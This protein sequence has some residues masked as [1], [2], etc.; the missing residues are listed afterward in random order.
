MRRGVYGGS[1]DPVHVGHVQ[2]AELAAQ[3]ARLD[4]VD[5]VPAAK[6]PFKRRGPQASDHDRLAMLAL[7]LAD[8][9]RLEV[10]DLEITR[11]GVSYTVDTLRELHRRHPGDELYFLMGA[12]SLQDLPQ[13]REPDEIL[14]LA[15]PIVVARRGEPAPDWQVLAPL[16]DES[17]M[18][19]IRR[20][21]IAEMVAHV[22]S[23]EVRRRLAS[24][25]TVEGML[26]PAVAHYI[27]Q[28]RLYQDGE[29]DVE[30]GERRAA[31]P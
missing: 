20:G 10:C 17:Q 3:R 30:Q 14:R 22:S 23:S 2:L 29:P 26:A 27:R 8:Q 4:V 13:W 15:R 18:E 31:P 16:V 9:P 6:Q 19:D 24:G 25:E 28:H 1:F 5:F 7:A 12:D 21:M 11:G